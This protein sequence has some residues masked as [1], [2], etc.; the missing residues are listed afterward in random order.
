V[1]NCKQAEDVN[2]RQCTANSHAGT[3][4]SKVIKR[5]YTVGVSRDWRAE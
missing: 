3:M 1:Y 2:D 4:G 5:D